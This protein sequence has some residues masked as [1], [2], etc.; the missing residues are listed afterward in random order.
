MILFFF[1]LST[2]MVDRNW[3]IFLKSWAL[4]GISQLPWDISLVKSVFTKM[5]TKS[6]MEFQTPSLLISFTDVYTWTPASE[7]L[8]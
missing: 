3:I 6:W 7:P 4:F 8:K 2:M 1:S 5:L